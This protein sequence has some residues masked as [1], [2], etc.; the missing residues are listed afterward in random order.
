MKM[1]KLLLLCVVIIVSISIITPGLVTAAP[2]GPG[3]NP[4]NP[5]IPGNRE[6]PGYQGTINPGQNPINHGPVG[7]AQIQ[8]VPGSYIT[9]TAG[10]LMEETG[11]LSKGNIAQYQVRFDSPTLVELY[12]QTGCIFTL[13]AKKGGDWPTENNYYWG[14]KRAIEATSA[15]QAQFVVDPGVWFF[16][17]FSNSG[18]GEYYLIARDAGLVNNPTN[19]WLRGGSV[20]TTGRPGITVNPGNI[21]PGAGVGPGNVGPGT[22]PR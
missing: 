22:L 4:G 13:Y 16:T 5:G 14:Y 19:P 10:Y 11:F 15:N 17:I 3:Q 9:G 7:T 21:G 18:G 8:V 6:D 1:R 20:V 12:V 2:S